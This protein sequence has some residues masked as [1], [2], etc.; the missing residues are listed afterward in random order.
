MRTST[1]TTRLDRIRLQ[2]A[3]PKTRPTSTSGAIRLTIRP[4]KASSLI[5]SLRQTTR[6]RTCASSS[7]RTNLT[8]ATTRTVAQRQARR[9]NRRAGRLVQTGASAASERGLSKMTARSTSRFMRRRRCRIR[10]CS[11]WAT[12]LTA[13]RSIRLTKTS[14]SDL[15]CPLLL[16]EV[17]LPTLRGQRSTAPAS[18]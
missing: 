9:R 1:R 12:L 18:A 11:A 10:R 2:C 4:F 16:C 17:I 6:T 3:A 5:S 13:F 15:T 14:S 7:I 8:T